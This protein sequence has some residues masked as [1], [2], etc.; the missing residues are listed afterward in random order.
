MTDLSARTLS[1]AMLGIVG[2]FFVFLVG[3]G[4]ATGGL[5]P[6]GGNA[7]GAAAPLG[8]GEQQSAAM[9]D[10]GRGRQLFQQ[11]NCA[12]CHSV[13]GQAGVGPTMRNLAG[14]QR[15]FTD[16]T[17][18]VADD[19]YLKQAIQQPNARIVQ[20]YAENIMLN[21]TKTYQAELDKDDVTNALIAYIK[22]LK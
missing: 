15:R 6:A 20:G 19:E 21:V 2:V 17:T 9:A 11:F 14:A 18:A 13:N 8:G 5:L 10:V 12:A 7:G 3:A 22:S 1:A 4:L 16:G